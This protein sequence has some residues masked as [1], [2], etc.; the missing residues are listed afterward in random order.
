MTG[1]QWHTDGAQKSLLVKIISHL[2]DLSGMGDADDKIGDHP[3]R[4]FLALYILVYVYISQ[5]LR[6]LVHRSVNLYAYH[7]H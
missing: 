5:C 2:V 1:M 3:P 4:N 6:E 7:T